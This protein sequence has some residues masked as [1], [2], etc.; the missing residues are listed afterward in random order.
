VAGSVFIGVKLFTTKITYQMRLTL[1]ILPINEKL[2]LIDQ[3]DDEDKKA[4]FRIIDGLLTKSKFKDFFQKNV[5][6][7]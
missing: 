7:L 2:R 6:A 4:I 5:A 1:R 3:L